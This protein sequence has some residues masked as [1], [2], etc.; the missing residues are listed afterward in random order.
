MLPDEYGYFVMCEDGIYRSPDDIYMVER[1]R[2]ASLTEGRSLVDFVIIETALRHTHPDFKT[3]SRV[4][5]WLEHIQSEGNRYEVM[6]EQ[7]RAAIEA[8]RKYV[9]KEIPPEEWIDWFYSSILE[10]NYE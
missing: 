1:A 10:G 3:P 8:I 7:A 2:V 5:G 6:Q 4:Q 9:K